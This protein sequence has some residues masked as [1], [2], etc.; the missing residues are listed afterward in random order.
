M[1]CNPKLSDNYI[2]KK[3]HPKL[4]ISAEQVIFPLFEF[5]LAI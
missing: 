3:I 4:N 2:L 5:R 1:F